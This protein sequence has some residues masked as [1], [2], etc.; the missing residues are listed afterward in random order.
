MIKDIVNYIQDTFLERFPQ[1]GNEL[2][3][4]Q[5]RIDRILKNVRK[6]DNK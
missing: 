1:L 2:G 4:D 3:V 5:N 6:F